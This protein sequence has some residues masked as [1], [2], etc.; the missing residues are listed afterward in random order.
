MQQLDLSQ[1][2]HEACKRFLGWGMKRSAVYSFSN[3]EVGRYG[4]EQFS[5][6]IGTVI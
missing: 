3:D 4:L 1:H 6:T 2:R 5:E